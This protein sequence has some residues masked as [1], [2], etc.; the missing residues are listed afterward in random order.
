MFGGGVN[1]ESATRPTKKEESYPTDFIEEA[2]VKEF[3]IEDVG[4]EEF[5]NSV[6]FFTT[7]RPIAQKI[8]LLNQELGDSVFD[9]EIAALS[10][11]QTLPSEQP[12]FERN[13]TWV[14]TIIKK[15]SSVLFHE[16]EPSPEQA[17]VAGEEVSFFQ[18]TV[19][20]RIYDHLSL[21]SL[22][23]HAK[24]GKPFS[25]NEELTDGIAEDLGLGVYRQSHIPEE[26]R[27][28][29]EL[30]LYDLAGEFQRWLIE[31]RG[32][33]YSTGWGE[34][35]ATSL[36]NEASPSSRAVIWLEPDV[37][38]YQVVTPQAAMA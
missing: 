32:G 21:L 8:L 4:V 26:L 7:P 5:L 17:D 15:I 25:I 12:V 34:I 6:R 14:N 36:R 27:R 24:K 3:F 11:P 18:K 30:A 22:S 20:E 33:V 9:S 13:E 2:G 31:D 19:S 35:R 29:A 28:R 37:Q 16:E 23:P 38:R 10:S 1:M